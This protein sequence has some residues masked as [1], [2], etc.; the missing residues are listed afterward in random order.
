M[1]PPSGGRSPG[2]QPPLS[3]VGRFSRPRPLDR[4]PQRTARTGR[5]DDKNRAHQP[6]QTEPYVMAPNVLRCAG[7][8]DIAPPP[9]SQLC[10]ISRRCGDS[11]ESGDLMES[12]CGRTRYHGLSRCCQPCTTIR[13]A[14]Y[15]LGVGLLGI[16]LFTGCAPRLRV[17][18][19]AQCEDLALYQAL[20][21]RITSTRPRPSL[22]RE[23]TRRASR[24]VVA[25]R[26]VQDRTPADSL[27]ARGSEQL[28]AQFLIHPCRCSALPAT[29]RRS[30]GCLDPGSSDRA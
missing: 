12:S 5:G 22:V 27:L 11:N 16:A 28:V 17:R 25:A 4:R 8:G 29:A 14:D 3:G 18:S 24:I 23:W 13:V 19:R 20:F 26:T 6:P 9:K 15:C 2:S 10:R 30:D 21:V 1:P 7:G